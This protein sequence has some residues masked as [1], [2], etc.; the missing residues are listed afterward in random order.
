MQLVFGALTSASGAPGGNSDVAAPPPHPRTTKSR[1]AILSRKS[2]AARSATTAEPAPVTGKSLSTV[3]LQQKPVNGLRPATGLN[4]FPRLRVVQAGVLDFKR[5]ER[6]VAD[7]TALIE[8]LLRSSIYQHYE[9]AYQ[10]ATGLSLWLQPVESWQLP[11]Q[12]KRKESAFAAMMAENGK[13]GA[14]GFR[15][16][17]ELARAVMAE[18]RTL[19][20]PYGLF[21]TVVPVRLGQHTVGF[22]RTGQVLFRAPS[23]SQLNLVARQVATLGVRINRQKLR[24]AYLQ[25]PVVSR[26]KLEACS[27]LLVIFADHLAM[28]SNQLVLQLHQAEPPVIARAREY[29]RQNYR[30]KLS[31]GAVAEA[32]HTTKFYFCKLFR[33]LTGLT[34]TAY[35]SRLRIETAKSLLLNPNLRISEIAF[36]VGFQS[37]THFNLVFNR[38]TGESPTSY[39]SHLPIARKTWRAG[40]VGEPGRL[41]RNKW[42][43]EALPAVGPGPCLPGFDLKTGKHSYD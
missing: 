33:K 32:M 11:G 3:R 37:L 28:K 27:D 10:Q 13:T 39:R 43:A 7:D 25:T 22:L 16:E 14:A 29:I 4:S 34:F 1:P 6:A 35:V 17:E 23:E 40:S 42:A 31:L 21:E 36:E 26:K 20:G 5:A 30:E 41:K 15:V 2:L 18:P 38:I 8:A 9:R 24:K 12:G 19:M